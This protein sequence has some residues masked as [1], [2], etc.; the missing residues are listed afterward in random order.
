MHLGQMW[1]Q[2]KHLSFQ[3]IMLKIQI[4][5]T[6]VV[7]L[8]YYEGVL[9]R[10]DQRVDTTGC[11]CLYGGHSA[12][13]PPSSTLLTVTILPSFLRRPLELDTD[14]IWCVLP[15]SFPENFV[16]KSTNA[17]KPKVTIS[18]PGAMLNIL[19]KVSLAPIQASSAVWEKEV[20]D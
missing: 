15:N 19:V 1:E 6:A 14:G 4:S 13:P 10:R 3:Q 16:I 17:K 5:D 9:C 8:L 11:L 7:I 20:E 18:Y 2:V 12:E